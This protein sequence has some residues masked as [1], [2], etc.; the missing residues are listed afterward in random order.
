ML[1]E[2]QLDRCHW[3]FFQFFGYVYAF[4]KFVPKLIKQ[5]QRQ[6]EIVEESLNE[7]ND[8]V[9]LLESI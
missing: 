4:A 3:Q 9:E 2:Y 8:V 6:I 7:V 5:E 1:L